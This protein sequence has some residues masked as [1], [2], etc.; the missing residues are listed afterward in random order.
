MNNEGVRILTIDE[1]MDKLSYVF[2]VNNK[3]TDFVKM[4]R[5]PFSNTISAKQL[6]YQN[7]E[8]GLKLRIMFNNR[9]FRLDSDDKA[10]I[11]YFSIRPVMPLSDIPDEVLKNAYHDET[12]RWCNVIKYGYFPQSLSRSAN[13]NMTKDYIDINGDRCAVYYKDADSNEKLI[14]K[15]IDGKN[16]K[17]Y[18]DLEPVEWIVDET[19]KIVIS[20]KNLI[21]NIPIEL[22]AHS[23]E[24]TTLY[25]WL[26]SEF[27]DILLRYE[28]DYYLE[29]LHPL[30]LNLNMD[31]KPFLE[32]DDD[33]VQDADLD[34]TNEQV[35]EVLEDSFDSMVNEASKQ[36]EEILG[37]GY[38]KKLIKK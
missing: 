31:L 15:F 6:V 29:S 8:N 13:I 26:N 28:K 11:N 25:K 23:F 19:H 22:N 14:S 16:Q 7:L 20:K 4:M 30:K 32:V 18:F 1:M 9:L 10:N 38:T 34:N 21:T 35:E 2:H 12:S 3:D 33:E 37:K 27:L 36:M 5:Y 24:E 17:E